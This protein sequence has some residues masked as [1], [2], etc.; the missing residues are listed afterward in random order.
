MSISYVS[1][2]VHNDVE[3]VTEEEFNMALG[4]ALQKHERVVMREGDMNG[5]R[6]KSEYI[7]KLVIEKI[8]ENRIA[9]FFSYKNR[10]C[11]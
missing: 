3:N 4:Q 1:D 5:E 6:M 10:V 7:A 8:N 2:I 11:C 9:N